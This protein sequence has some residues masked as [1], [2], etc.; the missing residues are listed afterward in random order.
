[1]GAGKLDD[2][3]PGRNGGLLKRRKTQTAP[4]G[5]PQK[6]KSAEAYG[7]KARQREMPDGAKAQNPDGASGASA[8]WRRLA[9][10]TLGVRDSR[11]L[12]RQAFA[13]LGSASFN[14]LC[15]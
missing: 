7:A 5:T 8:P 3:G 4:A 1:M 12:R 10:A 9:F 2:D 14:C 15:A 11:L 6:P 13:P